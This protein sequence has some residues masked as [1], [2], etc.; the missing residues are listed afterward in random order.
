MAF[1]FLLCNS[2]DSQAEVCVELEWWTAVSCMSCQ[3]ENIEIKYINYTIISIY[4]LYNDTV[5]DVWGYIYLL[6]IL[7]LWSGLTVTATEAFVF[8]MLDDFLK[9]SKRVGAY[10]LSDSDF[11]G[12]PPS[13]W[14]LQT[15]LCEVGCHDVSLRI[16]EIHSC[17]RFKLFFGKRW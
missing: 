4:K 9:Q 17:L 15:R 16:W 14:S 5:K 7:L 1:L 8:R 11:L 10:A 6:K 12:W 3:E 13:K 2:R